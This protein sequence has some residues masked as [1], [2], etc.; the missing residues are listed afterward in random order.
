MGL[1]KASLRELAAFFV[2]IHFTGEGVTLPEVYCVINI[3]K[4]PRA[5]FKPI[6]YL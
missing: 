3:R 1:S 4:A 5:S 6:I 2:V